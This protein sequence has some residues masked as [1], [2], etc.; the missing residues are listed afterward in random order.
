[1]IKIGNNN[2][3][4]LNMTSKKGDKRKLS[5]KLSTYPTNRLLRKKDI[6]IQANNRFSSFKKGTTNNKTNRNIKNGEKKL[7]VKR[8]IMIKNNVH[9]KM[10]LRL[11]CFML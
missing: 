1:M 11:I 6:I 10:P 7:R 9:I 3:N 2:N 4:W 8:Y 5:M